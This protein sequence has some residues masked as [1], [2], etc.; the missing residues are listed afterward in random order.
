MN[1]VET[2]LFA[3]PCGML[4]RN[5]F[6]GQDLLAS[7]PLFLVVVNCFRESNPNVEY[8]Q[9]AAQPADKAVGNQ[10]AQPRIRHQQMV[11]RPLW[12]PGKNHQKHTY[13]GADQPERERRNPMQPEFDA[14]IAASFG[15][16]WRHF[17]CRRR[18]IAALLGRQ[19]R[20]QWAGWN[21]LGC[22]RIR[23]HRVL[24]T[25]VSVAGRVLQTHIPSAKE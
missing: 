11:V 5:A 15:R 12:S 2:Y 21:C 8:P 24:L 1:S 10:C 25:S 4:I 6:A 16:P 17:H 19:L 3:L 22:V 23:R 20:S 7:G 13:D 14:H 18:S 9:P